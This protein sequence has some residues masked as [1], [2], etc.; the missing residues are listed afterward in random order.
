MSRNWLVKQAIASG[1][2]TTQQEWVRGFAAQDTETV[3]LVPLY[4]RVVSSLRGDNVHFTEVLTLDDT[5]LK[6]KRKSGG[7]VG[8]RGGLANGF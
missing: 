8:S 6:I 2:Q 3:I 4:R 1:E 7:D 5:H